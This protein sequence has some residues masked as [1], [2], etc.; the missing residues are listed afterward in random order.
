MPPVGISC[1]TN[2]NDDFLIITHFYKV[3]GRWFVIFIFFYFF[4][5]TF[6]TQVLFHIIL[7]LFYSSSIRIA[8]SNKPPDV[9]Y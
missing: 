2:Y 3:I 7:A 1:I 4:Y 6:N 9:N 5:Q 8:K